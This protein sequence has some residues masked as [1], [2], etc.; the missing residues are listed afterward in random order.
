MEDGDLYVFRSK[1]VE[2]SMEVVFA[3]IMC[4]LFFPF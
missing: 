4:S 3:S 2:F 1:S